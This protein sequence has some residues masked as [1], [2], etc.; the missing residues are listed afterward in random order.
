[1]KNVMAKAW[2]IARV[3]KIRFGGNVKEYFA[4]SLKEA[5]RQVKTESKKITKKAEIVF[6]A[7]IEKFTNLIAKVENAVKKYIISDTVTGD[8][9]EFENM[10]KAVKTF[11][12]Y[13]EAPLRETMWF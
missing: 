8:Y 11:E 10:E 3:A 1:M 13:K 4:E 5:W 12:G 9:E 7:T 2:E 6:L